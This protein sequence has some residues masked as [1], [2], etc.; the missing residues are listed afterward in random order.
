MRLALLCM[1][2]SMHDIKWHIDIAVAYV[3]LICC[4]QHL[5]PLTAC[6]NVCQQY[7][8]PAPKHEHYMPLTL[9]IMQ[10]TK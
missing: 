9:V 4:A 7:K 2:I 6:H 8:R 1:C 10:S 3:H 5:Q